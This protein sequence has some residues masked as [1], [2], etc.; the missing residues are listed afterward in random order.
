MIPQLQNIEVLEQKIKTGYEILSFEEEQNIKHH[1]SIYY[2]AQIKML[3]L[4]LTIH[5]SEKVSEKTALEK[6]NVIKEEIKII[7]K[8]SLYKKFTNIF[9]SSGKKELQKNIVKVESNNFNHEYSQFSSKDNIKLSSFIDTKN[10]YMEIMKYITGVFPQIKGNYSEENKNRLRNLLIDTR[11]Q[12]ELSNLYDINSVFMK[13]INIL[14]K[15]NIVSENYNLFKKS[16]NQAK[17][18]SVQ[19]EYNIIKINDIKFTLIDGYENFNKSIEEDFRNYSDKSNLIEKTLNISIKDLDLN[20]EDT[21]FNQIIKI[22]ERPKN[23]SYNDIFDEN[24]S[25]IKNDVVNK[26]NK[27]RSPSVEHITETKEIKKIGYSS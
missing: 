5:K 3:D 2:A 25:I 4:Y 18:T 19:F 1:M 14:M 21:L 20:G 6:E 7:E 13:H 22:L 16:F 9:N 17:L 10:Q 23:K 26:V 27:F 24:G 11:E 8:P 15:N 12:L